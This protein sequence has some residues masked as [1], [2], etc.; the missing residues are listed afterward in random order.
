M[1]RLVIAALLGAAAC[2]GADTTAVW[3]PGDPLPAAKTTFVP[4]RDVK[5]TVEPTTN[6]K[7]RLN[8]FR[9]EQK[10]PK[11]Q[12]REPLSA[13]QRDALQ[14]ERQAINAEIRALE[15]REHFDVDRNSD[16]RNARAHDARRLRALKA[17]QRGV[18]RKL[19][20]E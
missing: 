16:R 3:Q 12:S 6:T 14:S 4:Q 2:S 9:P 17:R 11:V 15:R 5:S 10:D 8:R 20:S 18:L 1:R 19:R 7:S 13:P